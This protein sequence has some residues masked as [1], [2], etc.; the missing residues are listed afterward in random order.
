[1]PLVGFEGTMTLVTTLSITTVS[2]NCLYVTLSM[3][4]T[5]QKNAAILLSV[6]ILSAAFYF[7]LC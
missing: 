2:I 4:D 1:M 5:Q 6:V 7:L 3:S